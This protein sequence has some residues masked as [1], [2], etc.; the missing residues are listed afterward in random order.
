MFGA[1]LPHDHTPALRVI[2]N[3][4]GLYTKDET[5][6]I[7]GRGTNGHRVTRILPANWVRGA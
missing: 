4:G 3:I 5:I 6:V 2:R 1:K 7:I